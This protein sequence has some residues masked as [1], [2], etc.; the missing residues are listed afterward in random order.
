MVIIVSIFSI[1]TKI[2]TSF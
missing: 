2:N 1:S